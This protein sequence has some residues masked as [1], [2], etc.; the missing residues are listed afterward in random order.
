MLVGDHGRI[1][2]FRRFKGV[3]IAA[4]VLMLI[5]IAVT[6]VLGILY[7]GQVHKITI[8]ESDLTETRD[9]VTKLRDEKDLLLTQLVVQQKQL[10][11]SAKKVD[12]KSSSKLPDKSKPETMKASPA[13][14]KQVQKPAPKIEKPKTPASAPKKVVLGAEAR[15]FKATYQPDQQMLKATFRIYNTSKPK[16]P[17]AGR[18][19][20]VFKNQDDPTI[21]W[22]AVPRVQ[23]TDGIPS[24]QRGQGFKINNSRTVN[25]KAYRQKAP[26]RFNTASVYVFSK[27]G[28]KIMTKDFGFKIPYRPPVKPKKTSP[29]APVK[30][31][32]IPAPANTTE[33]KKEVEVTDRQPPSVEKKTP[34]TLTPNENQDTTAPAPGATPV[35]PNTPM[36][37]TPS[38]IETQ[39]P[40]TSDIPPEKPVNREGV[41]SSPDQTPQ[42]QPK[43]PTQG[44]QQ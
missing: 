4:I 5:I 44:D 15:R 6:V 29:T 35:V 16:K 24:G 8:L 43:P 23:L 39:T 30:E 41:E 3:M 13:P 17:L 34:Q 25:F 32:I 26:I 27:D 7:A 2:P 18:I 28:D 19:V 1:I 22:L 14:E 9:Q 20:V 21:K 37:E 10:K 11:K 40:P 42:M 12:K 38:S 36:Q 31:T 33:I